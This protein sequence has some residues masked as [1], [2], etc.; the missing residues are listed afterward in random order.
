MKLACVVQR[1]GASI[2]GGSEAHCR[3]IA[4]RL[5][6]HH[7]VTVL[8]TCAADYVTWANHFPAGETREDGVRV[9][10]FPVARTR[11]LKAFA[12]AGDRVMGQPAP[13]EAQDEWFRLNGPD[14]PGLLEHLRTEG[15]TYD[16]VL[17]WT[18]RYAPSYFGL[19]LVAS[20]AI[21]VPTAEEDPAVRLGVLESYF[22]QPAGYIF[23]TPEE[24]QLVS[25]SAG[26]P[27]E[28]ATV[29][30]S[31]LDPASPA[32]TERPADLPPRF[33]LYLGRIDRNK[34]C[35]AL[36]EDFQAC[37]D[38]HPD[39]TLVLAGPTKIAIPAHP[40][41]MAPGYVSDARREALLAWA[42]VLV[43]PS[44]YES[45]S[46]VLL[47]GWNHRRPALVNARCSPLRGQVSRSGGGLYYRSPREFAE[48]LD[49]LLADGA[50]RARMGEAG[51]AYV[52]R[53]YRWPTV[54]ARV[55]ALIAD[56]VARRGTAGVAPSPAVRQD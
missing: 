36:L 52:E 54:M 3:D 6:G 23:L 19:P 16:A 14:T 10:R 53:E 28:P 32:P 18:F 26:Q 49:M 39:V 34:G 25:L 35:E 8:T 31:G 56:V 1:Y 24:Q 37:A 20:R 12:E 41:I 47:E 51:H 15:A 5:A 11:P 48:G 38:A 43:V 9:L 30:G 45:L 29:T 27:L 33:V 4:R 17:F 55:E 21:L 7:D 40:R 2:A 46:L 44:P 42:D 22:R 13:P 50:L